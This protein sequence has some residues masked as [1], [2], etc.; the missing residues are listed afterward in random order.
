MP[1]FAPIT[2]KDGASTPV[3][4]TFNPRDITNGVATLTESSGVP[5]GDNRLTMSLARTA[6]GKNKA[7][8][9][10][11]L[12]VV[13]DGIVNGVTRPTLVR[14]SYVDVVMTFEDSSSEQDR[15]NAR[16]LASNILNSAFSGTV[17]DKLQGIY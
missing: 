14:T 2:V 12:P 5:M 1:Q 13:Q 4:R 3:D 16:V 11:V 6:A 8:F 7:S 17:V 9:K 15:K 10:L